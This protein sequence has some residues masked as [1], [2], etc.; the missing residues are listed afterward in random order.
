MQAGTLAGPRE[1]EMPASPSR[2][3][4]KNRRVADCTEL[5][6]KSLQ[7]WCFGVSALPNHPRA[8]ARDRI[9]EAIQLASGTRQARRIHAGRWE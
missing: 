3:R 4:I 8:A 9:T 5:Y 1:S 6:C 7:V 2:H